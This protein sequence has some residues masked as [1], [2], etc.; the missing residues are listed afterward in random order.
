MAIHLRAGGF[1][2]FLVLE[3]GADLGGVWRDNTYPGA[4]CDAPSHLYSYSFETDYPWSWKFAPQAEIL[5]YLR[6]CADKYGASPH[7]R[8]NSEV[9]TADFDERS[10]HW[11]VR[12]KDVRYRARILIS[13]VGQ[14]HAPAI[15]DIPGL[16]DFSGVKFHSAQWNHHHDL[17]GKSVAVLGTGASAI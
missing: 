5:A 7:I 17:N 10:G 3:K 12:T 1:R 11:E 15:P 13:A 9:L 16:A 4:A 2:S 6:H 8:V 14:L